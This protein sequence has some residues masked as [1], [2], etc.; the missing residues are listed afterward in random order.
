MLKLN[1]N[2]SKTKNVYVRLPEEMFA[3]VHKIAKA[4]GVTLQEVI[5]ALVDAGLESTKK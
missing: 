4:N 2:K 1:L 5:R 3:Q